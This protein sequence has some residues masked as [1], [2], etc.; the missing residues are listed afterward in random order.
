MGFRLATV[1][2][3]A[4][5][6]T[7][8]V[9]HDLAA[10]SGGSFESD[11]MAAIVRHTELHDVAAALDGRDPDGTVDGTTFGAPVPAPRNVFAIGLNYADH[12]G[13]ADMELPKNPLVFTKWTS[14]ITG[15]TADVELR[16]ETGDYEAELVVVIGEGGRDIASADAWNHVA[17]L[18]CGQD[19]SDRRLQFAAKPPHFDLGKSRDTYGPTGPVL[20]STDL[21]DDPADLDIVCRVNGEVRQSSN[22]KHLIFDVP[23]LIEY[24][25]SAI[26]LAAGDVIF[27]GTPDGVGAVNGVYL[28]PGDVVETEITGLGTMRNTCI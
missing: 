28:T 9:W 15:P 20:V 6:I 14:C 18:M 3:R 17:G 24:I 22:T 5:L 11:P 4:V 23:K 25:S 10:A 13:E 26:T 7:G 8:A 12:A 16:T 2:S 19:I 21:V 1:D 27:T